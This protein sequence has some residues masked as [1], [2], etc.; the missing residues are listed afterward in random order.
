MSL[1]NSASASALLKL[2][3]PSGTIPLVK[4]PGEINKCWEPFF[5]VKAMNPFAT[6]QE[7]RWYAYLR[8][9]LANEVLAE[10]DENGVPLI[11]Q[12]FGSTVDFQILDSIL[13]AEWGYDANLNKLMALKDDAGTTPLIAWAKLIASGHR[14]RAEVQQMPGFLLSDRGL[15][16]DVK[17]KSGESARSIL[18]TVGL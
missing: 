5:T 13:L 17:N 9:T 4:V 8:T 2:L 7:D 11:V 3:K 15:W 6:K 16:W 12:L 1:S 14:D 18:A 10:K